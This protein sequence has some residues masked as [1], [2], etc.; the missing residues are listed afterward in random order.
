MRHPTHSA[1]HFPYELVS[2]ATMPVGAGVFAECAIGASRIDDADRVVDLG[3]GPGTASR[4]AARRGATVFGVDPTP[5][6]LRFARWFT[7]D[8]LRARITWLEGL[9]AAIPLGDSEATVVIAARAA[10]HFDDPKA[11]FEEMQRVL[12]PGGRVAIV[13]RAVR[14]GARLHRGHGFTPEFASEMASEL[15]ASG[16]TQLQVETRLSGRNGV[17]VVSAVRK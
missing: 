5:M 2:A 9:A 10:H 7:R 17:I 14:P 3:C 6:M 13:E 15:E 8:P 1:L 12:C 11:A 16:F 4:A